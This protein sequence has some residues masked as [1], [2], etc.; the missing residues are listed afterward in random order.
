MAILEIKSIINVLKFII[1]HKAI[2][3]NSY[4]KN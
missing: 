1:N 4:I 3:I 2:D